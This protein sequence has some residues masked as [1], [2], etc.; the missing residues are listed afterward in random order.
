M[1]FLENDMA[2]V[3]RIIS[4]SMLDVALFASLQLTIRPPVLNLRHSSLFKLQE[5]K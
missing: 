3:M 2:N 1:E 5:N 4:R